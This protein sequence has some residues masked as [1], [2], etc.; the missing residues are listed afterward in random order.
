VERLR[1]RY[2][3]AL[4]II[5][6]EWNPLMHV[7]VESPIHEGSSVNV[8][9]WAK[10]KGMNIFDK[11]KM[12]KVIKN[13]YNRKDIKWTWQQI[14][15]QD[16]ILIQEEAAR[17]YGAHIL[18]MERP[19]DP[20]EWIDYVDLFASDCHHKSIKGH[21]EVANR[22][23]QFV[24]EVGI[25][26]NPRLGEWSYQDQCI[27][28]FESGNTR[29]IE[30]S[31]DVKLEKFANRNGPKYALSFGGKTGEVKV[32]NPSDIP[33]DL[34]LAYMS[35]GPGRSKYPSTKVRILEASNPPTENEPEKEIILDVQTSPDWNNAEVHVQKMQ[36]VGTI[37]PGDVI[38]LFES[39]DDSIWPF[40]L[41]SIVIT[42]KVQN[43]NIQV[44]DERSELTY[45]PG[46]AVNLV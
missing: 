30:Y 25:V 23:G 29:G 20:R 2:P 7:Y 44:K 46:H 34:Y 22:I 19:E 14:I 12:K 16:K 45:L 26:Q 41:V 33:M 18:P 21:A 35:T 17:L 32:R 6:R 40:R 3:D 24:D 43:T 36:G 38:L 4:I 9:T 15:D 39:I 5:L 11:D 42:Q 1:T 13:E 10:N 28:W 27:T 37:P 31:S 8:C